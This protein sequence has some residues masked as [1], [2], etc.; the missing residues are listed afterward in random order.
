MAEDGDCWAARWVLGKT[1]L[2]RRLF[3]LLRSFEETESVEGGNTQW[4]EPIFS[5]Q[6]VV[7]ARANSSIENSGNVGK[8]V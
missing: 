2:P 5:H 6:S 7:I 4:V 8:L 3:H 1:F